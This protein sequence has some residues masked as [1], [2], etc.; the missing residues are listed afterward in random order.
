M[1]TDA[2]LGQ[3][4]GV[5]LPPQIGQNLSY[6]PYTAVM[7]PCISV[8]SSTS[9]TKGRNVVKDTQDLFTKNYETLLAGTHRP[10]AGLQHVDGPLASCT[11]PVCTRFFFFFPFSGFPFLL[12]DL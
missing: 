6:W 2:H 11:L 1:Y 7:F 9:V 3:N 10:A 8:P 12:T 4:P 5:T